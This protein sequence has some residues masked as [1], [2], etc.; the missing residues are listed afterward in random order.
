MAAVAGAIAEFVAEGLGSPEVI[1]ENGG[2]LYLK[3][4]RTR[5]IALFA[6]EKSPFSYELGLSIHPE[7]T[8]IGVCTSSGTVGHAKSFGQADAVT[9]L[10][11]NCALADAAATA[12]ANIVLGP[13]SIA[14]AI[15]F[16]QKIPQVRGV[17]IACSGKFGAW[18]QVE[19]VKL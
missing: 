19:L 12:V 14:E 10:S 9:I 18:G 8:P 15:V 16:A 4:K 17:L 1:I 11:S 2:D 6:G 3:I 7:Q 5:T 13:D